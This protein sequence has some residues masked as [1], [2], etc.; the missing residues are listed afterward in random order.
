MVHTM[1]HVKVRRHLMRV[2]SF[3]PPYRIW[4]FRLGDWTQVIRLGDKCL[5]PLSHCTGPLA[6]TLNNNIMVIYIG[7][8][9]IFIP[10]IWHKILP[11]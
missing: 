6:E 3:L 1:V 7:I 2:S 11:F 9:I 10:Y 4:V 8:Y 5:Y